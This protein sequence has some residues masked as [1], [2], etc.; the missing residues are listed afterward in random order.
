MLPFGGIAARLERDRLRAEGVGQHHNA[1]KYLNQDYEALKQGC[2]E[3]G[4]LFRDPQFPA[5]PSALGFK[6]LGPHSSKT[7]GVEW[8]RPSVSF[9]LAARHVGLLFPACSI[10]IDA[11]CQ[12]AAWLWP[13]PRR[14]RVS[15][16]FTQGN[17]AVP[18]RASTAGG[19]PLI[20]SSSCRSWWVTL[21]S[22]LAV[23]PGRIS[24]RGLWVS[25]GDLSLGLGPRSSAF[26]C[27]TSPI[28]LPQG[29]RPSQGAEARSEGLGGL[30]TAIPGLS[31]PVLAA[32]SSIFLIPIKLSALAQH[33]GFRTDHTECS[34]QFG[35]TCGGTWSVSQPRAF[36][37]FSVGH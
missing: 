34:Q 17:R 14:A 1:V 13:A 22:S 4:T 15:G 9:G 5:G 30:V 27:A 19:R 16:C 26:P 37:C 29:C 28:R 20:L 24:A 23:Q 12:A 10:C 11:V 25:A 6:E 33:S 31:K 2:I 21:S 35:Q 8:K 36:L 32:F 3:S 18:R 7:R